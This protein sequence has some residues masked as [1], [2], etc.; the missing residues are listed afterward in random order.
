MPAAVEVADLA[1]EE[2][3][4]V[5]VRVLVVLVGHSAHDIEDRIVA[6]SAGSHT[7]RHYAGENLIGVGKTVW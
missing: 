2:D 3:S 6:L 1:V 7:K 4:M 5:A